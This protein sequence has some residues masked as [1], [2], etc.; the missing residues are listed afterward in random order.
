MFIS[1]KKKI[2]RSYT[3]PFSPGPR[4]VGHWAGGGFAQNCSN[5]SKVLRTDWRTDGPTDRPIDKL[6]DKAT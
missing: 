2:K 4:V 6:V 3:Q 5:T 1:M